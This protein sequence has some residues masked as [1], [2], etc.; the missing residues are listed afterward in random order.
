[1]M[2]LPR[3]TAPIAVFGAMP[4]IDSVHITAEYGQTPCHSQKAHIGKPSVDRN[5]AIGIMP[6]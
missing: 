1:M 4:T 2:V 3:L 5:F 6:G